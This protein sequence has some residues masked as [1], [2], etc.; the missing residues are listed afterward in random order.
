MAAASSLSAKYSAESVGTLYAQNSVG[1]VVHVICPVCQRDQFAS[2]QG[3]LVHCRAQHSLDFG[4]HDEA[5]RICGHAIH[6]DS[7]KLDNAANSDLAEID[8][9]IAAGQTTRLHSLATRFDNL[10][11]ASVIDALEF[12][13]RPLASEAESSDS[14]NLSD[15]NDTP[16][17]IQHMTKAS[18]TQGSKSSSDIP[19]AQESRFHVIRRIAL[20][21]SS[22][23]IAPENRP[24]GKENSTHK[25][26]VYIRGVSENHS[27]AEYIRKVR[28]FLH[29]SYRPDD[30][31]D[32]LSPDFA[33]TRWGWGEFPVRLQIFFRDKRNKPVDLIHMLKLDDMW[34][35]NVEQGA[36]KLIDFELDRRGLNTVSSAE[37]NQHA[38][39]AARNQPTHVPPTNPVL[40]ELLKHLCSIF[41]LVLTD[42]LP[43]NHGKLESSDQIMDYIPAAVIQRWTWGVAV[44]EDVWR[45]AW[46]IGKRLAAE[47]SRNRAIVNLVSSGLQT[48]KE[49][50]ASVADLIASSD[51]PGI[52]EAPKKTLFGQVCAVLQ[53]CDT[54]ASVLE[55]LHRLIEKSDIE[56]CSMASEALMVWANSSSGP[57][58]RIVPDK[59]RIHFP[60]PLAWSLKHPYCSNMNSRE[61]NTL[62][63]ASKVLAKLPEGWDKSDDENDV[64]I[65]LTSAGDRANYLVSSPNLA[66]G[67]SGD[68]TLT[69]IY[70]TASLIRAYH[71]EQQSERNLNDIA[72]SN[73]E[74]AL[75][76]GH[77][78]S[79]DG[80]TVE[81]DT[82]SNGDGDETNFGAEDCA[83]DWIWSAIR[84]LELSCAP[85]SRFTE[86]SGPLDANDGKGPGSLVQLPNCNDETFGEALEQRLVV[87]RLFVDI[88]RLFL[89]NI[90][91]ASDKAM[92][93]NRAACIRANS[94]SPKEGGMVDSHHIRVH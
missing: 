47:E 17:Y 61:P 92:R 36:E 15:A 6:S 46:P 55:S 76:V 51:S 73:P 8:S 54:E 21:N 31:V 71:M 72:N 53:A 57:D 81:S 7:D 67:S 2:L 34:T 19:M 94:T 23:Y 88:A 10:Q 66:D 82:A 9:G 39:A 40:Y 4:T 41:P 13:N 63:S 49:A 56:T 12:I 20:G 83:V 85:A 78:G 11:M 18:T 70:N 30:I 65:M 27:T 44:S 1:E 48:L 16:A 32:L 87:G 28:V 43:Y 68:K 80:R 5:V 25:W 35:G 42:A 86:S 93:R 14:G 64:D 75:R 74:E 62:S 45:N 29:P 37:E 26:T 38:F 69:N 91:S 58:Q 84:P 90:V 3:F 77:I 79:F 33:L 52:I 22:Q 89:R 50:P 60:K 59:S 24:V